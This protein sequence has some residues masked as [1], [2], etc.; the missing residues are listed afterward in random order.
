VVHE[1]LHAYGVANE[2]MTNCFAVQLVPVFGRE[3]G[4]AARGAAYLGTLARNY[5]RARAPTGY[6]DS[7][8]CRDGGPWDLLDADS[9]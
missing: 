4:L 1:T 5:V 3:L 7:R 6:W 2:A 8:R 9:L